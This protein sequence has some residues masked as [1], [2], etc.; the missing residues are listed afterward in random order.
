VPHYSGAYIICDIL[1]P[2]INDTFD[3]LIFITMNA[4]FEFTFAQ[5]LKSFFWWG[6]FVGIAFFSIYPTTNWLTGLRSEHLQLYAEAELHIPFVAG[7]IWL[8]LS[9]YLLFVL[10][11]FFL[12]P[13]ELKRLG[14][15]LISATVIA[16]LVFLVF[17]AK[18]GFA[19]V[20]PEQTL[21]RELFA[22]LFSIDQPFNLLPSLHVVY[23]STI[24]FSIMRKSSA[25]SR[26]IILL[27]L[28]LIVSST[29][30]VHQHHLADVVTGLLLTALVSL[31]IG[32]KYA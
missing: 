22:A 28:M 13:P 27:W 15:E 11:P 2:H 6:T 31:F 4:Q 24:A 5:R 18:L 20:I 3:F 16:G 9:M 32:R 10:P 19:R 8:Y 1:A 7:F 23:S 12:N 25:Y 30:L 17:P 26:G 14:L 29:V 21:Y